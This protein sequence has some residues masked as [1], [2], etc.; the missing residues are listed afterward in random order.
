[1]SIK[2]KRITTQYIPFEDRIR[3]TGADEGGST[4]TLWL[5]QRLINRLVVPLCDGLDKQISPTP[6]KQTGAAAVPSLQA[7]MVQTFAQ[8]KAAAELPKGGPVVLA[9]QSPAWLVETVV[10]KNMKNNIRMT[11][12]G[13]EA[14][15]QAELTLSSFELRQWLG[16]VFKQYKSAAWATQVWPAWVEEAS[17]PSAPVQ[18]SSLH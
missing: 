14:P 2:L 9:P 1:M 15:Q 11:F 10:I 13:L 6:P 8:Q 16:I 3:L 7:H 12:K 5:T 18:P 4:L 17:M